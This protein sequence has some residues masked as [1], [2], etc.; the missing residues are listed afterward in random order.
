MNVSLSAHRNGEGVTLVT[1]QPFNW[2]ES[3]TCIFRKGFPKVHFGRTQQSLGSPGRTPLRPMNAG[4]AVCNPTD[5][6][7]TLLA[8]VLC[9]LK[10]IFA[11]QFINLHPKQTGINSQNVEKN[12]SFSLYQAMFTRRYPSA[13]HVC[14]QARSLSPPRDGSSAGVC[15]AS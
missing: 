4:V 9:L 5:P 1:C 11:Q 8:L 7:R 13:H 6:G 2:N 14:M 10:F 12:N 3:A 15:I